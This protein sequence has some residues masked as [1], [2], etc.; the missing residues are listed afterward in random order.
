MNDNRWS[1]WNRPMHVL[2][3]DDDVDMLA[4][5][6]AA[7][8]EQFGDQAQVDSVTDPKAASERLETNLIDVLI[9]DLEMPGISGLQLLRQAKHRNA[10]TQVV[11]ITGRSATAALTEAMNS[12]ASDYLV[13]PVEFTELKQVLAETA[14][15]FY[16][17]CQSLAQTLVSAEATEP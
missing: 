4:L 7:I 9:T 13:K 5:L 8:E 2:V 12:G 14:G 10:W 6:V 3:V 17:W 11:V 1:D 16:R 15:R